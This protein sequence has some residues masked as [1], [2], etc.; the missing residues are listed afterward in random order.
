MRP[1]T[2]IEAEHVDWRQTL[3]DWPPPWGV[4]YGQTGSCGHRAQPADRFAALAATLEALAANQCLILEVLL[5][6]RELSI[7][8]RTMNEGLAKNLGLT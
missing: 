6:L 4:D 8:A 5:D 2:D 1:R 7:A 3:K